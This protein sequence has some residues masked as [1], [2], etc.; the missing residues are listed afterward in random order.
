MNVVCVANGDADA[1]SSEEWR[2]R[3]SN[4]CSIPTKDLRSII[5]NADEQVKE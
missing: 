1:R 3:S 2:V 4:I 5:S